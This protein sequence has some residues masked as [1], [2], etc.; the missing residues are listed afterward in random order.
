MS[1]HIYTQTSHFCKLVVNN[2]LRW[3][4]VM[5]SWNTFVSKN[6]SSHR[7]HLTLSSKGPLGGH[8]L[9]GPTF[10]KVSKALS[11]CCLWICFFI[12]HSCENVPPQYAHLNGFSPVCIL[13]C[14]SSFFLLLQSLP[15]SEHDH[16][17]TFMLGKF[18]ES[19][20][21][22]W[23]G[24]I[25]G[26]NEGWDCQCTWRVDFGLTRVWSKIQNSAMSE[27]F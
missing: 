15:Q 22:G 13:R 23:N 11:P 24:K 21:Y 10:N 9:S 25:V 20:V 6:I 8:S 19:A 1:D 5:W 16:A 26:V 3:T 14:I 12:L 2:T 18:R 4:I 7:S 17:R 27:T